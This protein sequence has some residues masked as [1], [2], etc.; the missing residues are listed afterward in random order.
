METFK[1]R[2]H[3]GLMPNLRW[4]SNSGRLFL[5][6]DGRE[7]YVKIKPC[8]PWVDGLQYLS[9]R[10]KKGDEVAFVEHPEALE[11]GSY[12]ALLES[13]KEAS[14]YF[15]VLRIES[16]DEEFELRTWLVETLQGMRK[17]QTKLTD[18]PRTLNGSL[19]IIQDVQKDLFVI[20]DIHQLDGKS[21][22]IFWPF[23]D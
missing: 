9:L 3:Q 17:F 21:Q 4:E 10:N 6:K 2:T 13:L 19:Y 7:I 5:L 8:F 16:M 18:W 22:K 1:T 12:Q 15:N 14:F 23:T 20:E 11:V